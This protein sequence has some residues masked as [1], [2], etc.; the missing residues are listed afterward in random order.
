MSLNASIKPILQN[1]IKSLDWD[2]L[3]R[4]VSQNFSR[5]REL[6]TSE[7]VHLETLRLLGAQ[8]VRRSEPY[9]RKVLYRGEN[10]EV[11]LATWR[12][13]AACAPHDHGFSKG[14]VWLVDG[15]FKET[16]YELKTSL[17][18][19]GKTIFHPAGTLLTV[20]AGDIHSMVALDGGMSLHIYTPPIQEMK[21]FDSQ[22]R[23]TLTVDDD[24]GAWIPF[25]KTQVVSQREWL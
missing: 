10:F 19:L 20:T 14:V 11:M 1:P 8:S 16:H 22:N 3:T 24:C 17:T 18:V 25:D 4:T 2:Y 9:G 21:V 12:K 23:C 5:A 7:G 6:L 13:G 15:D